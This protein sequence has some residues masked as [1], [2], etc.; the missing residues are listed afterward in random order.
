MSHQA[1]TENLV[2]VK[3]RLAEKYDRLAKTCSSRPRRK[4]LMNRAERF[5]QQAE[6]IAKKQ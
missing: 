3:T 5:R 6:Q 2:A 4:T 1:K